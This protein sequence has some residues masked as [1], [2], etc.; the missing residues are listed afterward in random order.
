M[1]NWSPCSAGAS[2]RSMGT[3]NPLFTPDALAELLV[4]MGVGKDGKRIGE[5]APDVTVLDSQGA[6][7]RLREQ[8]MAGPLV[9]IFFRGGWCHYC[10]LQLR[11]WQRHHAELRR[12]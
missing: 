4:A 1:A 10:N 5:Q 8:W 2:S 3:D 9:V 11:D 6:S 7:V 12:L